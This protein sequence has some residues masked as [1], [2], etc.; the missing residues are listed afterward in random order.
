[1]LDP[2]QYFLWQSEDDDSKLVAEL[3]RALLAPPPAPRDAPVG[4]LGSGT[5][6]IPLDSAYYISR[7]AD[8]RLTDAVARREGVIRIKGPRQVGKTSLL[9]RALHE[10]G[11][12]EGITVARTDYQALTEDQ[13]TFYKALAR[14]LQRALRQQV[15]LPDIATLWN[16]SYS[17]NDNLQ[18][19]LEYHVL[20]SLPGSLIW[21]MDEV[22]R[23]FT[24]DF[25][26]DVFGFFRSWYNLRNSQPDHPLCRLTLVLSYATEAALFITDLN[27]SPFNVGVDIALQDFIE[28]ELAELNRRFGSPLPTPETLTRFRHLVGGHPFLAHRALIE[29]V[30]EGLTLEQLETEAAT[31]T[32][33]FGDH[34]RRILFSTG[35]ELLAVLR[36][37]SEGKP[38][39]DDKSFYR[40]CEAGVLLGDDYRQ[41]RYRC[42]IYKDYLT[43]HLCGGAP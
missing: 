42:G 38:C 36:A 26:S 4:A 22:D 23:L 41:P 40:L 29:M 34:L 37:V 3:T 6:A 14:K 28:E 10:A 30:R 18:D 20:E 17:P 27:Q 13:T 25:K 11:Q 24:T 32:G 43:R 2:L 7:R 5:G 21:G 33:L 1:V 35:E 16:D 19:Y 31:D 8:A 15:N 39:P 12:S 9:N